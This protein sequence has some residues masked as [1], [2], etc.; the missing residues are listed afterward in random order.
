M[1][2]P[3][4]SQLQEQSSDSEEEVV[5]DDSAEEEES[6]LEMFD[7][8]THEVF[9]TIQSSKSCNEKKQTFFDVSLAT[10]IFNLVFVCMYI[11]ATLWTL[12]LCMITLCV[13]VSDNNNYS[14]YYCYSQTHHEPCVYAHVQHMYVIPFPIWLHVDPNSDTSIY[15]IAKNLSIKEEP[16]RSP[17]LSHDRGIKRRK[18]LPC[19]KKD[20]GQIRP[21]LLTSLPLL[22]YQVFLH[23]FSYCMM[24]S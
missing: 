17:D 3:T 13:C 1:H 2:L 15:T 9:T 5:E 14:E 19:P 7:P 18:Q 12:S 11:V 10:S 24:L 21:S 8:L 6:D 16:A 23:F 4:H 20:T 22:T